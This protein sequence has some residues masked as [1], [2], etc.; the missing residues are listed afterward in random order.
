MR[1]A[2]EHIRMRVSNFLRAL[3]ESVNSGSDG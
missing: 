3:R 2:S 1:V